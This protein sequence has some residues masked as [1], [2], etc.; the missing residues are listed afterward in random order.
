[1]GERYPSQCLWFVLSKCSRCVT[2][3]ENVYTGMGQ[4]FL[5]ISSNRSM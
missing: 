1:M 2:G 4:Y 3:I 5:T